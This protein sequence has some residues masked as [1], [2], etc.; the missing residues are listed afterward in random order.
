MRR[1]EVTLAILFRSSLRLAIAAARLPYG[2]F[3]VPLN[4]PSDEV[5]NK[6]FNDIL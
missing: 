5:L 2:V 4:P 6:R 1:V 3:I